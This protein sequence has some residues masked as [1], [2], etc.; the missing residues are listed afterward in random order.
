MKFSKLFISSMM[1]FLLLGAVPNTV[2]AATKLEKIEV[3]SLLEKEKMVKLDDEISQTLVKVNEKNTELENLQIEIEKKKETIG[4]TTAEVKKQKEVVAARLEQAQ[5]RLQTIQTS[6]MN[7]NVVVSLF[8]SESVTDLFN[9]AYVLVTLQSA[10]ND[11]MNIAK[12]EQEKLVVL[13]E[14]LNTEAL[15]LEEQTQDSKKQK[16]ALDNQ[17]ASLQKTM[18]TNQESLA[19]LDAEKRAEETKLAQETRLAQE[20][21]KKAESSQIAVKVN[22][23]KESSASVNTNTAQPNTAQPNTAQ[24]NTAQPNTAQPK[25]ENKQE[26]S[27][28]S[29]GRTMVVS[30]T[31]Y[32]TAQPGL[33]THT[34]TGI[35]LLQN[36][37]V[38]AVDPRVIPLG[39]MLEIPGYGVAIAGDTGGAIKGNKIDIHFSTVGQALSWGRRTITIRVLN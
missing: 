6:E 39:T 35:N 18:D 38:I 8:E 30:A 32:S 2:F 29:S 24:P 10:G 23:E 21:A 5:N 37:M 34:A 1:V 7:Q 26:I 11:Q 16:V 28:T 13:Q 4:Q 36:P 19:K 9:R 31:G 17:V 12:E 3:Q 14:K 15:V 20:A 25:T 33:S 27:T 22:I